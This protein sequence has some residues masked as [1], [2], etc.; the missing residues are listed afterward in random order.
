MPNRRIIFVS[1]VYLS[2]VV[3]TAQTLSQTVSTNLPAKL[4][5]AEDLESGSKV[6]DG[7]NVRWRSLEYTKTLYNP[8]FTSNKQ[9]QSKA[10]S[11]SLSCKVDMPE[12]ELVLG[13]CNDSVIEQITDSQGRDVEIGNIPS[14]SIFVYRDRP[15]FRV[16]RMYVGLDGG[17]EPTPLRVELDCGLYKRVS[18][19]FGLKGHFY[20]LI[21]E[22][23]EYVDLPFEPNDNWLSITSDVEIRVR[24]ARN[25]ALRYRFEIEQRPENVRQAF[26]MRVGDPL[27]S[28]FVVDRQIIVQ[29]SSV[30]AGG[31][32]SSGSIGGSG[33]GTGRAEIIRYKIAVNPTHQ[34]I[35]FELEHIP[36]SILSSQAPSQASDSK[37]TSTAP[38]KQSMQKITRRD[39]RIKARGMPEQA[40]PQFDKKIAR[41]FETQWSSITCTK[42]L[43]NPEVSAKGRNQSVS[44]SLSV[45]CKSEILDPRLIIGTCD[46]PV[47]EQVTDVQGRD[48]RISMS[49][50]A[51]NMFYSTLQYGMN[52]APPSRLVQW[53]GKARTA[54]GLPLKA[55]HRAIRTNEL[56]PVDIGIQLDPGLLARGEIGCIKGYF[57]VLTAKTLKHVKVPFK[58]SDKW[59]RLTGDVEIQL[60]EVSQKGLSA[61]Y[62][63]KQRGQA[64]ERRHQLLVG[65]ILPDEIVVGRQFIEA[66]G[67][68]SAPRGMGGRPLPERVSVGGSIGG[69]LIDKIDFQIAFGPTQYKIPFEIENIPLPKPFFSEN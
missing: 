49:Q 59:V 43:Y 17:P 44:E 62:E 39:T 6:A 35:P 58:S 68:T 16:S 30:G 51:W 34:A 27:P 60:K 22:S 61:R 57:H 46:R 29:K 8:A 23:F 19:D 67:R 66:D 36:L 63:I 7:L 12:P 10:E 3:F 56:Q 65:D 4:P 48:T 32:S 40:E 20:A 64:N 50:P 21:A 13:T 25:E 9:G 33:S 31:S 53:E 15:R 24:E 5:Y 38:V 11:L 69:R 42:M 2:M 37:P 47:I 28:R 55:R 18:G 1:V 45:Y 41:L 14:R 52:F 26:G 54:L